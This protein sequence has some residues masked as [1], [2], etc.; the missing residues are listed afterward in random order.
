VNVKKLKGLG[1]VKRSK[2]TSSMAKLKGIR[3]EIGKSQGLKDIKESKPRTD[4]SKRTKD[5]LK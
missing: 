4:I 5:W 3:Q 1:D 2:Q